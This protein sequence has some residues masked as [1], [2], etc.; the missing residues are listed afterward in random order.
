[1]SDGLVESLVHEMLHVYVESASATD[2]ACRFLSTSP[3]RREEALDAWVA[4]E[5]CVV[6]NT[7]LGYFARKGGLS[8]EV[9]SYYADV[10]A[11]WCGLARSIPA[12]SEHSVAD[13]MSLGVS[14]E[15]PPDGDFDRT[16]RL[17]VLDPPADV[18]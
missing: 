7:S 14:G 12:T 16:L 10:A 18:R 15:T 13:V 4:A 9:S 5:E 6:M 11:R 3:A 8:A 17:R 1:M 2:P